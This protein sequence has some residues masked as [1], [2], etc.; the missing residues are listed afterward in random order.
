M[1]VIKPY[2]YH[3]NKREDHSVVVTCTE[4][5]RRDNADDE[6]HDLRSTQL[7][8]VRVATSSAALGLRPHRH[9]LD[10]KEHMDGG[11]VQEGPS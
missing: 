9:V 2:F 10:L 1:A 11:N 3:Q 5:D 8:A 6:Q 7:L 4:E